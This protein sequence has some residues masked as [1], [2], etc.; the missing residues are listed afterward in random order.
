MGIAA[1]DGHAFGG[2]QEISRVGRDYPLLAGQQCDLLFPFD[3]DDA[4]INFA[5]QQAERKADDARAVAAHPLDREVGFPR[6]GRSED[7]PNR[8]V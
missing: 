2:A 1:G 6:V 7:G 3:R 5:G 8:S 4:V